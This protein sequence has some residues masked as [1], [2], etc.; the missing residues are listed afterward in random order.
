MCNTF[1]CSNL[2]C[3]IGLAVTETN[4]GTQALIV[5]TNDGAC[6]NSDHPQHCYFHFRPQLGSGSTKS[7]VCCNLNYFGF[8]SQSYNIQDIIKTTSQGGHN[9]IQGVTV[10]N[11]M[12]F[13]VNL[14]P[15]VMK[16]LSNQ[17]NL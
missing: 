12:T 11:E 1:I 7:N 17:S 8:S 4:C 2:H 3:I 15:L 14:H 16:Y 9:K 13:S 6:F 5:A 10:D